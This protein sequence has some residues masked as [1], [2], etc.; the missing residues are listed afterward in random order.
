MKSGFI[1]IIGRPSAGKSTLLNTI[2]GYKISIT[3]Q[4]PQTTR[5]KI[6][7]IYTDTDKGQIVFLDTPGYHISDKKFNN[8]MMEAVHSSI[9]E[10]DVV[11]YV[12]DSTKVL[13]KEEQEIIN[14]VNSS[15]KPLILVLNKMDIKNKALE[16]MRGLLAVNIKPKAIL[17]ISALKEQGI[18]E[19]KDA[20]IENCPEGP[21]MYPAEYYTDQEPEFRMAEIIREKAIRRVKDEVPHSIYVEMAD[22]EYNEAE[23]TMWVR[24][25]L[26]VE[27]E[28]QKGFV[29]GHKGETIKKIRIGAQRELNKIFPYKIKLDLRVKVNKRWRRKDYLLKGILK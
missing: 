23:N 13:G 25:F 15:N 4:S 1:A 6:R 9:S 24:A 26:T 28:S 8:Y 21:L 20:L 18:T 16:E 10:A 3:A 29:I 19:L 17:E 12:V 14:I 27:Q 2:C 22:T 7:G 5:N 11:M